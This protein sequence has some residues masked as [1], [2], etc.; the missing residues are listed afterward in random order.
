MGLLTPC[1]VA[2]EGFLYTMIVLEEGFCPLRVVSWGG[3][4]VPGG[5][6]VD[7]IDSCIICTNNITKRLQL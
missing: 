7:E 1:F 5:M 4:V 2:R 6:V 3:G